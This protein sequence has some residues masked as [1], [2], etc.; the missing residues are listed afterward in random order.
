MSST[1]EPIVSVIMASHNAEG[2]VA[3]AIDSVLRQTLTE[4][5]LIIVDDGSTDATPS[6]AQAFENMDHRVRFF[7]QENRGSAAAR[8]RAARVG[9][10][11]FLA[12][13]D[14]DDRS[15]P[16]RLERQVVAIRADTSLS[17]VGT[18]ARLIDPGGR[19]LGLLRP[20]C[21][22]GIIRDQMRRRMAFV[23]STVMIRAEV[24]A[25]LGGYDERY[26]TAE[27]YDLLSRL[28]ARYRAQSIPAVL[29]DVRVHGESKTFRMF[30]QQHMRSLLSQ[31]IR[32]H[33]GWDK[34]DEGLKTLANEE[35]SRDTLMAVGIDDDAI[36]A[37]LVQGYRHRIALLCR[38]GRLDAAQT[39]LTEAL[40]FITERDLSPR[41]IAEF[42]ARAA[43]ASASSGRWATFLEASRRSL[44]A[45]FQPALRVLYE[46]ART[47]LHSRWSAHY[48]AW[49]EGE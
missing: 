18:H 26:P 19:H 43:L 21:D 34:A 17:A 14:A 40:E 37:S 7:A 15:W 8:N 5:E 41:V 31:H 28:V 33:G 9:R 49:R 30:A 13:L 45:G 29:Y 11:Q 47:A 24:F 12:I 22:Y 20:P 35:L 27:D 6:I 48:L 46:T 39:L 23:H 38:I 2:Y 32:E 16:R 1:A 42:H 4:L 10:G 3:E 25:A 44:D 36:D